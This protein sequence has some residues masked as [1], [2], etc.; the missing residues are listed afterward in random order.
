MNKTH[1]LVNAAMK[2]K[3]QKL[4]R[5]N[6]FVGES[7]NGVTTIFSDLSMSFCFEVN[8]ASIVEIVNSKET[9]DPQ[10]VFVTQD[11]IVTVRTTISPAF[12]DSLTSQKK[13]PIPQHP[14]CHGDSLCNECMVDAKDSF[15][16]FLCKLTA[17][18]PMTGELFAKLLR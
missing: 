5:I 1:P 18:G 4:H 9:Q 14:D 8:D 16:R 3:S 10:S 6:G 7:H 13:Q 2:K 17:P 11:A 12:A 15:D